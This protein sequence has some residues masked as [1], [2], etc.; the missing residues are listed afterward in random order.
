M[1]VVVF[2]DRFFAGFL[3]SWKGIR[4]MEDVFFRCFCIPSGVSMPDFIFPI[5]IRMRGYFRCLPFLF[6]FQFTLS[7][8]IIETS[9]HLQKNTDLGMRPA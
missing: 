4:C 6:F 2:F 7:D 9:T 8:F 3:A 1:G 5:I